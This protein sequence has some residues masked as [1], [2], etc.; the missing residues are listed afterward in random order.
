[1]ENELVYFNEMESGIPYDIIS[2]DDNNPYLSSPNAPT[3]VFPLF[4]IGLAPS[5]STL[6]LITVGITS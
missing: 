1:M 4:A 5:T 3:E 2:I 6:F